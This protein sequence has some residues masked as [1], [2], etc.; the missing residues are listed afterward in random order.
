MQ[1]ARAVNGFPAVLA[2]TVVL[3]TGSPVQATALDVESEEPLTAPVVLDGAT[4]FRVRG[5]S[6]FSPQ[7]RAG[8]IAERIAAVAGDPTFDPGAL[9][10]AEGN[11]GSEILAGPSRL[12]VV[13]DPDAAAER[14]SRATVAAVYRDRIVDAIGRSRADRSP[15]ARGRAVLAT[16]I[17]AASLAA[18][19]VLLV[20]LGRRLDAML[21]ARL[22]RQIGHVQLGS[23]KLIDADLIWSVIRGTLRTIRALLVLAACFVALG[24][25]LRRFPETRAVAND[26]LSYVLNP[27]RIMGRAFTASLPKLVFVAILVVIVRW[28]LKAARLFFESVKSG[29]VTLRGFDPTWATPT[30]RLVRVVVLAFALVVAYPYIP[31]SNSDAFKGISIFA[32]VLLSLGSSSVIASVI[33]GYA[34]TY[35]RTFR[36][37]DRVRVGDIVGDVEQVGLMVTRLRTTKNEEAVIPNSSILQ[38]EVLNYSAFARQD[39]LILHTQVGI[40]YEVPWRQVEGMLLLAAHR[41]ARIRREPPPF[42]R[43]LELADFCVKYELN[44]YC[45]D[46][47]AMQQLYTELHRNVLDAFNEHGVQIMTPAYEGDPAE[48]KIVPRNHW[49]ASPAI[50]NTT[51]PS[52]QALPNAAPAK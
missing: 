29:N 19:L 38:G 46:A 44:V 18:A 45:D 26:L 2:W 27:P 24:L 42:V 31:G 52:A 34:M 23:F 6:V 12:L 5:G 50:A 22:H 49:Y 4:L 47:H 43:H 39:G 8:R 13:T 36:V 28:A 3:G 33:A 30:Y 14:A 10:I 1:T 17:V 25:A 51:E 21:G 35:R 41:T 16:L 9:R 11:A 40:G 7:E 37:G 32:G 20:L 48:P 15:A